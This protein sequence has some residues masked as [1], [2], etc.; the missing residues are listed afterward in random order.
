MLC[1]SLFFIESM[2]FMSVLSKAYGIMHG[3]FDQRFSNN[4]ATS[5]DPGLMG[6]P[7]IIEGVLTFDP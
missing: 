2:V 6:A 4:E 1:G 3:P 7:K 5:S